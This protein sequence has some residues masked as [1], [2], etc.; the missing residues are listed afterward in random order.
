MC[1][2][3][4]GE[5]LRDGTRCWNLCEKSGNDPPPPPSKKNQSAKRVSHNSAITHLSRALASCQKWDFHVRKWRSVQ[6]HNTFLETS[7]AI[8]HGR[9]KNVCTV[10]EP[11]R[12]SQN[13]LT[14]PACTRFNNWRTDTG[15]LESSHALRS[16][17]P[18]TTYPELTHHSGAD[19]RTPG[20]NWF[21]VRRG[22]PGVSC[23]VVV[24]SPFRAKH[25]MVVQYI[26]QGGWNVPC[27]LPLNQ[28]APAQPPDP[29]RAPPPCG[30]QGG[31]GRIDDI[32]SKGLRTA[33]A[34]STASCFLFAAP[35]C[36]FFNKKNVWIVRERPHTHTHT[37]TNTHTHTHAHIIVQWSTCVH[38]AKKFLHATFGC[39]VENLSCASFPFPVWIRGNFAV[40]LAPA[41][42]PCIYHPESRVPFTED[43]CYKHE[44]FVRVV[45]LLTVFLCLFVCAPVS[46]REV[47]RKECFQINLFTSSKSPVARCISLCHTSHPTRTL[48]ATSL[49]SSAG[50]RTSHARIGFVFS[51]FSNFLSSFVLRFWSAVPLS[52]LVWAP[53]STFKNRSERSR[54]WCEL[55][56]MAPDCLRH[57]I[58]HSRNWKSQTVGNK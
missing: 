58:P 19:W 43:G 15:K 5:T 20:S 12:V 2:H 35:D 29:P 41:Q 42:T 53:V 49:R 17:F 4:V 48:L 57:L 40:Q 18:N 28:P 44:S 27:P 14:K 32:T 26:W 30:R 54:R 47:W 8:P 52:P 23:F 1:F 51:T 24:Q 21:R 25:H 16:F 34:L 6:A 11:C 46:F 31:Q 38:T 7:R 22:T 56:Q 36:C 33:V 13:P 10:W 37:R 50:Q 9:T 55:L 39:C 3:V 45:A